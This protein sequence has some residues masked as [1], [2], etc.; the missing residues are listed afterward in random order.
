[1]K[2]FY[3]FLIVLHYNSLNG[4]KLVQATSATLKE[5]GGY[6]I[7]PG[8]KLLISVLNEPDCSVRQTIPND[9]IIRLTYI[10]DFKAVDMPAKKLESLVKQEYIQKGIFL[11]PI[12]NVSIT[13]Y[14]ERFVYISGAVNKKGPFA[15]PPEI[16]AMN[17]VELISKLL[18]IDFSPIGVLV[19][20]IIGL[21]AILLHMSSIITQ[22][23]KKIREFE[24][25][26]S[27]LDPKNK[28]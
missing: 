3:L 23:N 4:Q 15:L 9:G 13:E 20:S 28:S 7:R 14:S 17:I 5:E 16:E 11:R 21:G 24:K 10:G 25:R 6:R 19:I 8:D 27:I 22:H 26:L 2:W 18:G 12:V 1:M